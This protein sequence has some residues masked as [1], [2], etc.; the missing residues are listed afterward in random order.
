[1]AGMTSQAV[2]HPTGSP[3]PGDAIDVWCPSTGHWAAGF[4]VEAT[5]PAGVTVRRAY[6]SAVLPVRFSWDDVRASHE[7]PSHWD[8]LRSAGA[9]RA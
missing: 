9:R 7:R 1:M 4:I 3:N 2:I 8:H 5:S 6:D